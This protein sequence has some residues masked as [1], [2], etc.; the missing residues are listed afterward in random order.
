ML[1]NK[2]KYGIKA[3]LYLAQFEGEPVQIAAIA[4]TQNMPKKFL[5]AILLELRNAGIL[6]SKKGKGGG[7]TL[8]LPARKITIGQIVRALDG[9][10]APIACASRNAF[11][12]CDDCTSVDLCEVR[13]VMLEVRDA[14]AAV[15]DHTSVDD[16]RH[17]RH[18]VEPL[19]IYDI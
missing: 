17:R 1:S 4:E 9:P 6:R 5:D 3:V 2:A 18:Q 14:I 12:P 7:Y 10:L 19:L 8:A 11:R 15:L 16:L 13:A